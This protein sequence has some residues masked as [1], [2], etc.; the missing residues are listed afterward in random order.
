MKSIYVK[1]LIGVVVVGAIGGGIFYYVKQKSN[2]VELITVT[3]GDVVEHVSVTGTT[4]SNATVSLAFQRSGK[5]VKAETKVG[6]QVKAGQVLVQL[7]QKEL[8][9][10]L[11]QAQSQFASA[12][13][14]LAQQQ[15]AADVQQEKLNQLK[16]G[17][18][19]EQIAID[20]ARVTAAQSTLSDANTNLTTVNQKAVSDL[21]NGYQTLV[22][23]MRSNIVSITTSLSDID[24]ILGVD[25]KTI[26]DSFENSLSTQG[27]TEAEGAYSDARDAQKI[28]APLVDALNDSSSQTDIDTLAVA[29][30]TNLELTSTALDKTKYVLDNTYPDPPRLT[31][32]DLE[33][34]KA[35]INGDR[36]TIASAVSALSSSTQLVAN[37]KLNN[38]ASIQL[39]QSK[40]N[41]ANSTLSSAQKQLQLDVAG[42]TPEEIAGQEAAVKQ[43]QAN[44]AAQRGSVSQA[45]AQVQLYLA[46]LTQTQLTAPFD[47]LVTK[48]DAKP[49]EI[50]NAGQELVIVMDPD[51]SEIESN[52]PE[53]DIGRVAL[54]QPVSITID[55]LPG[56]T[57]T[58]HVSY[59]EPAETIIEGVVNYKIKVMFDK[60]DVRLKS[61][62]T[63]NLEIE[64]QRKNNVLVIPPLAL[65]ENDQGTFVR[66]WVNGKTTDV[67]V[68][69]GIKN[70]ESAEVISGVAEG[71]QLV[72]IAKSN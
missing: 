21:N 14:Q 58:G 4:E 37:T 56:E 16:A 28:N 59:I 11:A 65:I 32:A 63:A 5:I 26:N 6:D 71:D 45:S 38:Q 12:E 17:T 34:K 33:A 69:L 9:A 46:Q 25:Q 29:I 57:F 48:Q 19:P 61:G 51:I 67:P 18:R 54:N 66:K 24:S 36:A 53:V 55:A 60:S 68:V 64:T 30:R 47:G 41:D 1:I 40:I 52:V 44:I 42:S 13:G 10:Q 70:S 31:V 27:R 2:K 8:L 49:G 23:T 43:A 62:L 22:D 15:A 7:D 3:R 72:N 20:Q 35:M 39:A 50:A